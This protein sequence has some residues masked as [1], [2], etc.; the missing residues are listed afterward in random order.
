M[1]NISSWLKINKSNIYRVVVFILT[2]ICIVYML[3]KKGKF[4][5]NFGKGKPWQYENLYAPFDFAILKSEED[6]AEEKQQIKDNNIPIFEFDSAIVKTVFEIANERFDTTFDSLTTKKKK[7]KLYKTVVASLKTVYDKGLYNKSNSYDPNKLIYLKKENTVVEV[8]YGSVFKKEDITSVINKAIDQKDSVYKNKLTALLF[9]VI[10]PNVSLNEELT[11]KA[12]DQEL[13]KVLASR[14]SVKKDT[15][16]IAKGEEVDLETFQI[17]R[18]LQNEFEAKIWSENNQ[19]WIVFGYSVLVS[20]AIL[21]LFLFIQQYRVEVFESLKTIFFIVFNILLMVFL[22]TTVVKYNPDYVYIVPVAILPLIVKAFS[23]ARLGLFTHIITILILSF[24]VPNSE[25]Y[26]FLQIIAG[27][28]TILTSAELYKRANLFISVGK[29]T[30]VYIISYIAF[31]VIQEGGISTIT[32]PLAIFVLCGFATLIVHPLIYGFEKIFGLVSDVSLLELSDTN[33]KLLKKLSNEAPGTFYH[34]LNVANIAEACANAIGANTMLVRVAALYHD[35]GKMKHP[36]F[37]TENQ[38][39]MVN[40]HD[41]L[42]PEESAKIIIDHVSDGVEIARKNNLP[43]R[44]IDFIKTHHGTSTVYYFYQ[45][46]KEVNPEVSQELFKYKGPTPYTKEMAILMM[47]DSVEAASKSLKQPTAALINN[48]VEKIID[49]QMNDG[50]FMEAD[51]TFKEIQKIKQ[52]MKQK[53]GNM[54]HLR[55]EYPK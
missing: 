14:G 31:H 3:P 51:I 1:I 9:D 24:I 22:T 20:L 15:R 28:V 50:Q 11:Q 13:S 4:K 10:Q 18:S 12:L 53:L 19:T 44:V 38:T 17:L 45:K 33:S 55:V 42:T 25:E 32:E 26:M 29:I 37:F 35:V 47:S 6:L 39:N 30:V 52:V 8:P 34:S 27:I 16:I 21:M 49:K 54:Y 5:Y 36:T 7:S 48:F 40:R 23:D 2:S 46:A 41:E 43:E